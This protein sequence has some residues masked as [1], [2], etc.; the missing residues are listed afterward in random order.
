M[1]EA[2]QQEPNEQSDKECFYCGKP[3]NKGYYCSLSCFE[4]DNL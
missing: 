3:I 2:R 1:A 4:G